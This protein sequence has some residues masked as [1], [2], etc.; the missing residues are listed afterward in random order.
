MPKRM[1]YINR[2]HELNLS[3]IGHIRESWNIHELDRN[4]IMGTFIEKHKV[5]LSNCITRN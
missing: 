1:Y 4:D 5:A 2:L 3:D